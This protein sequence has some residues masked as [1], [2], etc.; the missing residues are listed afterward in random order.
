VDARSDLYSA[1]C[2][3]YDLLTS[4]P[5][6]RGE[7]PVAIAY[8][9]VR[10]AP[11]PPSQLDPQIPRWADA[12]VLKAMARAP[13]DRYQSAEEMRADTRHAMPGAPSPPPPAEILPP[14]QRL[15]PRSW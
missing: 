12:V 14:G 7:S 11:G 8:Q 5:P 9:H 15:G 6:F 13:A 2:L 4:R 10:E 1:G 3:L